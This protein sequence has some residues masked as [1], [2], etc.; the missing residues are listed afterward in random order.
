MVSGGKFNTLSST[1]TD[2]MV[3]TMLA[4]GSKEV[5]NVVLSRVT[6]KRTFMGFQGLEDFAQT[7]GK[8]LR[9]Q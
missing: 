6:Q 1:K 5:F 4:S 3:C 7:F 9:T 8:H 2:I